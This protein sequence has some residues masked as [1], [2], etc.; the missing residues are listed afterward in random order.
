MSEPTAWLRLQ[1]TPGLGRVGQL[2]LLEHFGDL[3]NVLSAADE[4]RWPQLAGLRRDLATHVPTADAPEV[5][6]ALA[7]L[8]ESDA[9]LL[10]CLDPAY[11]ALLREIPDPPVVLYGR[12]RLP[13]GMAVAMVGARRPSAAGVRIAAEFAEQ[14]A[15]AGVVVVSGLA[16]GIDSAAHHGALRGGGLTV[17]VLGCGIDQ[18]YPPENR[19]LVERIAEQGVVLSEYPPGTPPLPGHFPGRNR[20]ISGLC[21]AVL[22]VEAA[23]DSGSLITADFALDQGREVMAVPGTITLATSYGPNRLLK[24]GAH[25]VTEVADILAL[26][27]QEGPRASTAPA[28]ALSPVALDEPARTVHALLDTAPRHIDILA[29][30]SGLTP[31]TLSDILLHLELQG[32]VRQLPGARFVRG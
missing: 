10:D 25:P 11:P 23:R 14:L 30:E 15:Q 17:A 24:Q 16:R 28:E 9:W 7:Q 21:R 32:L 4:R 1:L 18:V 20:I 5:V 29:R 12:G 22:V 31:M 27:G 8:E 13:D 26:L 2:R 3:Q 19:Q 6:Q